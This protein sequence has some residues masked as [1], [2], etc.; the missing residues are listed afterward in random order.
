MKK[1]K[2]KRLIFYCLVVTG[3]MVFLSSCHGVSDYDQI[4]RVDMEWREAKRYFKQRGLENQIL[5]MIPPESPHGGFMELDNYGI[6]RDTVLS[7]V[8]DRVGGKEI[9]LEMML[10]TNMDQPK[11]LPEFTKI[12]SI[13]L[14]NYK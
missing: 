8:H 3:G 12:K 14:R 4:I 1:I 9:I 13:N 5:E 6:A 7:I 2:M 11:R 10:I